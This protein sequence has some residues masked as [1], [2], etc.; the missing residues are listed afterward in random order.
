MSETNATPSREE[1][2]RV[3]YRAIEETNE[4]LEGDSKVALSQDAPLFGKQGV[5]DSIEL[6]NLVSA[7][8]QEIDDEFDTTITIADERA[9]SRSKSPFLTVGTLT[10][11]VEELL[12]QAADE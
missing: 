1:I 3:V 5:L 4:M 12:G 7:V 9:M 2:E 11:S 8:E 6:V 10:D